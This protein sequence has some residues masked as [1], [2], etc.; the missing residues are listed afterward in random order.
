MCATTWPGSKPSLRNA[1]K[2]TATHFFTSAA[3]FGPSAIRS[4]TRW[5]R[6]AAVGLPF[7]GTVTVTRASVRTLAS[8][9]TIGVKW[10]PRSST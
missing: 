10:A 5:M 1:A 6:V 3:V 4:S 8:A 9:L 7:A 2:P